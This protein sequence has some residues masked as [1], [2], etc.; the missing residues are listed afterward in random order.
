MCTIQIIGD[1]EANYEVSGTMTIG[2]GPVFDISDKKVS[3]NHAIITPVNNVGEFKLELKATHINP[4]FVKK[5]GK[6]KSKVLEKDE[7]I[8]LENGDIFSLLSDK[9]SFTV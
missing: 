7:K 8:C 9:H 2:R 4:C 3:R 5:P 1:N 6:D